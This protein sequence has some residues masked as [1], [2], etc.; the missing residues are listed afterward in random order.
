MGPDSELLNETLAE[1][2]GTLQAQ[3]RYATYPSPPTSLTTT[4]S[5]LLNDTLAE[6]AHGTPIQHL[7]LENTLTTKKRMQ[8]CLLPKTVLPV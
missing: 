6:G 3:Q 2:D 8:L 1:G 4:E 5:R 7:P